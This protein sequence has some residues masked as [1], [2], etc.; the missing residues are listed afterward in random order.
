MALEEWIDEL[1][2]LWGQIEDGQ[3]GNVRSYSMM[4]K[5]NFPEKIEKFPSALTFIEDNRDDYAVGKVNFD[6]WVGVTEFHILKDTSKKNYPDLYKFFKLI[7]DKAAA[8]IQLNESLGG[9]TFLLD[10]E[11]R[12]SIQGPVVL[13]YGTDAPH[14]GLIVNWIVKDIVTD[15]FQPAA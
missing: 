8:N 11:G 12:P 6:F 14:L 10:S 3:G 4:D 15:E 13:Q 7:R 2:Q 5:R 9:G 1:T